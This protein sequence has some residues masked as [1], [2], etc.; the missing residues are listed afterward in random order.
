MKT[1]TKVPVVKVLSSFF[2]ILIL[3]LGTS[4][5]D[6]IT[7]Q[8]EP[9]IITEKNDLSAAL[10]IADEFFAQIDP[11][12]RGVSRTAASIQKLNTPS[13]RSGGDE[14]DVRL[15]NYADNQGFALMDVRPGL[16]TIYAISPEGQLSFSDTVSNPVLKEFF[17]GVGEYEPQ[18]TLLPVIPIEYK[19]SYIIKEHC[20]NK[21]NEWAEAW[22]ELPN[23]NEIYFSGTRSWAGTAAIAV[24]KIMSFYK[25]PSKFYLPDVG[26]DYIISWD[27][28]LNTEDKIVK[29]LLVAYLGWHEVYLNSKY[30]VFYTETDPSNIGNTFRNMTYSM[31]GCNGELLSKKV[32]FVKSIL[33]EGYGVYKRGPV[34]AHSTQ[35]KDQITTAKNQYWIID[36]FVDREYYL[37]NAS[38][39]IFNPTTPYKAPTLLHCVWGDGKSPNGYYA[40]IM[41]TSN[42]DN[43][44]Q[45]HIISPNNKN[46]Q[47]FKETGDTI[48]YTFKDLRIY[49]GWY[50]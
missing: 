7:K 8:V 9:E 15:I 33:R 43:S 10:E 39:N 40:L 23:N 5:S 41:G 28:F 42:L 14:I 47:S 34:I 3:G 49:G 1:S 25:Y 4:C 20:I 30:K 26:G 29:Y 17:D 6:E 32:D 12:T 11:S 19:K 21:L 27:N 45:E 16:E 36:G 2:T 18:I 37:V 50:F 13:T 46:I 24:A 35:T 48:A 38:G 44:T 22:D 31:P